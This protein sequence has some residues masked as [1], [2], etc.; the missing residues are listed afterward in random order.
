MT[1][2]NKHRLTALL[3]AF[4]VCAAHAGFEERPQLSAPL[5][6]G[7]ISTQSQIPVDESNDTSLLGSGYDSNTYELKNGQIIYV[8]TEAD[9]S[10]PNQIVDM[11]N[12]Y[13]S[14][15]VGIDMGADNILETLTGSA[16][17][18]I[19]LS[20]LDV[21]AYVDI[22]NENAADSYVG[23]YS[24]FAR[25]KPKKQVLLPSDVDVDGVSADQL[26]GTGV[27]LQ[28]S[29]SFM[30]W[31][32][33]GYIDEA[34]VAQIGDEFI[35][36]IEYGA[37]LM[38]TLKFEYLNE[39]DKLEIGGELSVDWS[40]GN[41][42]ATANWADIK[43]AASVKVTISAY[44]YG[45]DASELVQILPGN[46]LSCGL[47]TPEACFTLFENTLAYAKGAFPNQLTSA[48]DYNPVRYITA[49]YD[50]SGWGLTQYMPGYDA[51]LSF[52]SKLALNKM[53]DQL[54]RANLDYRRSS[55]LIDERRSYLD[56]VTA[57]QEIQSLAS[58]NAF[59][60][61]YYIDQC[62]AGAADDC[63]DLW[64]SQDWLSAYDRTLLDL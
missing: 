61:D 35:Q 40:T 47:D 21:D 39:S 20:N 24:F 62:K 38:V 15:V 54:D 44:Q 30:G 19:G 12:T 6:S 58:S 10:T 13:A 23:T 55:Y 46:L 52:K 31:V 37:W 17:A 3:A 42:S 14:F 43:D 50:K 16:S 60:L 32:D 59:M 29:D 5:P 41:V 8:S 11:G 45:G 27:G 28:P 9:G 64:G 51:E 48:S 18:Q 1:I 36:A 63:Y 33:I 25:L 26:A 7:D 4:S 34:L 56:D 53:R 22:A 49:R 57:I 2:C